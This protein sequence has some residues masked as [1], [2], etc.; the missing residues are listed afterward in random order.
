MRYQTANPRGVRGS[1]REPEHDGADDRD[2][3]GI[4]V[5]LGEV[6][7]ADVV[8]EADQA[9]AEEMGEEDERKLRWTHGPLGEEGERDG[10]PL[11]Y[12]DEAVGGDHLHRRDE[13]ADHGSKNH[14]RRAAQAVIARDDDRDRVDR[15]AE[16]GVEL[17]FGIARETRRGD[18]GGQ[19]RGPSKEVASSASPDP[20]QPD[21]H[22]GEARR[23]LDDVKVDRLRGDVPAEPVDGAADTCWERFETFASQK[24]EEADRRAAEGDD[25]DPDPGDDPRK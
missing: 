10:C 15:R 22:P 6:R 3:S 17:R 12:R 7:A 8:A 24:A 4:H 2:E 9:A 25:L 14:H 21:K 1:E 16:R 11:G 19:K 20:L 13:H 23:S 18:R 5:D